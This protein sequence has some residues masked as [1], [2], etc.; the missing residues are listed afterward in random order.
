MEKT[1]HFNISTAQIKTGIKKSLTG[2]LELSGYSK[3]M[4]ERNANATIALGLYAFAIEEY[5]KSLF[6]K[7]C[8]KKNEDRHKVKKVVFS[9]KD[10]HG[11][12]F[13][14][15][16]S[17]LPKERT[18]FL[19][20]IKH[21]E[22]QFNSDR[23]GIGT[24]TSDSQTETFSA[25]VLSDLQARMSCFNLDWNDKTEKWKLPPK[26][27]GDLLLKSITVFEKH[28]SVELDSEY[29]N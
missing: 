22:P 19:S 4:L 24:K 7:E 21:V 15:A 16:F 8:M 5:G 1:D 13:N 25:S 17:T 10:S 9:G 14:K 3:D 23:K 12:K 2:S 29:S 28:V 27:D 11:K 18:S 6:L 20:E 26:V